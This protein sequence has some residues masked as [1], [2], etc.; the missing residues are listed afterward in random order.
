VHVC[1]YCFVLLRFTIRSVPLSC[2]LPM[3]EKRKYDS[4]HSPLHPSP[5]LLHFLKSA[6]PLYIWNTKLGSWK[7]CLVVKSPT[8]NRPLKSQACLEIYCKLI[9][10]SKACDSPVFLPDKQGFWC[11]SL[12]RAAKSHAAR[13]AD[14]CSH[15]K[16][17]LSKDFLTWVFVGHQP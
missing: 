6:N 8:P 17:S 7:Y 2:S 9:H 4:H 15:P 16:G 1:I 10:L 12:Q 5:K 13:Q 14:L 11:L 3:K